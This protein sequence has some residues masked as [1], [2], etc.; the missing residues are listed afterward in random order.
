MPPISVLMKPASGLCNMKCDY[1]FYCDEAA[2]REQESYG[3]MSEETLKNVIRRTLLRAEGSITYAFQGGEPTL[4]GLDFFKK[5]IAY[6]KQYN[7]GGIRISNALQTNGYGIDEDWCQ[8][9]REHHFLVGVSVDGVRETHD[10]YRHGKDGSPTFDRVLHATELFDRYGV[11]YNI[12]TV[13]NQNV[14]AHIPEIYAFFKEK[15]WYYQQYI[16]CL[17]PLGEKRGQN[18]YAIKPDQYGEFLVTLF[19]LWYADWKCGDAPC[20]RE[21]ENYI[22]LL[23]GYCPEA[24]NQRGVCSIQYVVEADGSVY[25]CDF[26]MLDEYRL[27]NLNED[28]LNRIAER[29]R[30]SGFAERSMKLTEECRSCEYFGLCR[31]GCQRNRDIEEATGLYRNY[32]CESFRRFFE[33]C[34]P[35]MKEVAETV[36]RGEVR[37]VR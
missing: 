2:K 11:D 4:R 16:A 28:R 19:K 31:G 6:E 32:F 22:G 30:E 15:G 29:G 33:A 13:V 12:L 14:A 18:E 7:K 27:G 37:P 1:C 21:F 8:F 24:C 36:R 26:Y 9:L 3:L 10:A 35:Q 25:P 17:D 20:I 5:V 23:L 34:L